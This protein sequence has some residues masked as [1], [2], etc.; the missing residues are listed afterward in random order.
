MTKLDSQQIEIEVNGVTVSGSIG[1][2]V[3]VLQA[4]NLGDKIPQNLYYSSSKNTYVKFEDMNTVH[5]WNAFLKH[6]D[7]Y[8]TQ[9]RAEVR[10]GVKSAPEALY[11]LSVYPS[12]QA[13]ESLI[14]G[15]AGEL[16][17]RRAE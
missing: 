5:L 13:D 2:V 14:N 8:V 17:S 7:A 12:G 9:L 11:E 10:D 16:L 4:M 1:K 15:L 3:G 6:Y